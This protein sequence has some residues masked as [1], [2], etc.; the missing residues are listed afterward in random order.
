MQYSLAIPNY[1]R[2]NMVIYSFINVLNN[3]FIDEIVINDD[4]SN[5]DIFS[6]LKIL[7]SNLNNSKIKLF[8]NEQ[9][10]KPYL[11]KYENVKKCK[12]EW[13]IIIDSDNSIDNDYIN[14]LNNCE[15]KDNIIY[16]PE[17]PINEHNWSYKNYSNI[18][19]DKY[20]AKNNINDS[21]FSMFLNTGNYCLNKNKYINIIDSNDK[22]STLSIIDTLYFSYLW[23]KD[24]QYF[25]IPELK[26]NHKVHEGSWFKNNVD[27]SVDATKIIV[28]KIKNE[29]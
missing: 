11:N 12:N 24:N 7:I 14:K 26:Y 23:L 15:L 20:Y 17:T 1:N 28:E 22:N 8:R 29:Y 21:N 4:F 16:C 3:E 2:D 9:N 25:I 10:L 18:T 19:I 13:V 27:V 5:E 6:N